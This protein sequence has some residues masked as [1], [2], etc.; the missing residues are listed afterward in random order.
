MIIQ[1]SLDLTYLRCKKNN[2]FDYHTA[3]NNIIVDDVTTH[4]IETSFSKAL[5]DRADRIK[6]EK[7]VEEIFSLGMFQRIQGVI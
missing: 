2:H 1:S 6:E 7:R 3:P 4:S 5:D